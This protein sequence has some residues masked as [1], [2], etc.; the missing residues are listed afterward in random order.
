MP[1]GARV[2]RARIRLDA[3]GKPALRASTAGV[4]RRDGFP[5][6]RACLRVSMRESLERITNA[7]MG[8]SGD[9]IERFAARLPSDRNDPPARR[10][11]GASPHAENSSLAPPAPGALNPLG[12]RARRRAGLSWGDL[13]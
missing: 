3:A 5:R 1:A 6:F 13:R 11:G 7:M 2:E 10:G 12:F 4:P 8:M 9:H